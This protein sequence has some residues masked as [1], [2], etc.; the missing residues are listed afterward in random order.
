MALVLYSLVVVWFDRVG[1]L[2]VQYPDRPWYTKKAEPSFADMLS[3]L[4]RLS[5]QEK[6]QPLLPKRGLLTNT[7][8]Q[9]ID[10][11]S[12]AA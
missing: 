12:R 7:V 5:W 2:L 11:V 6:L 8:R 1:Y 9:L 4:R 10:F 3:T